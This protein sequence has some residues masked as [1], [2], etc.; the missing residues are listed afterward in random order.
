[1][2]PPTHPLAHPN[3]PPPTH[4]HTQT[5]PRPRLLQWFGNLVTSADWTQLSLDE[6]TASWL[7]YKCMQALAPQMNSDVLIYR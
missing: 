2:H 5:H 1:M 6:G 7:E 3:A 4:S